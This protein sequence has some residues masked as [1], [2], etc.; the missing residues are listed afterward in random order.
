MYMFI[1]I[2]TFVRSGC[3][4]IA[5]WSW[6]PHCVSPFRP[7]T[8][9]ALFIS[10]V[11][12]ISFHQS[13]LGYLYSI[14][15]LYIQKIF[16]NIWDVPQFL[17]NFCYPNLSSTLQLSICASHW[18]ATVE[19]AS[20]KHHE[21]VKPRLT[22]EFSC[23]HFTKIR[24]GWIRIIFRG[25]RNGEVYVYYIYICGYRYMIYI[26]ALRIIGGIIGASN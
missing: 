7:A 25:G 3:K 11:K 2:Y 16:W 1:C 24:N 9:S 12:G 14:S 23:Q 26:Y 10:R 19:I 21:E 13:Y 5:I 22:S 18:E 20:W 17:E 8:L 15:Q 6:E 4:G